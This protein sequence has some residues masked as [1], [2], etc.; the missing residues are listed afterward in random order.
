M[1]APGAALDDIIGA[2][3]VTLGGVRVTKKGDPEAVAALDAA[4]FASEAGTNAI[5]E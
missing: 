5:G 3:D 1:V 4:D 2:I